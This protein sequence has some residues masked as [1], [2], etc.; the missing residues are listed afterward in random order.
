M[1]MDELYEHITKAIDAP[2]GTKLKAVQIF[3]A[4]DEYLIDALPG[5][6]EGDNRFEFDFS[7]YTNKIIPNE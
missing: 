2:Y 4:I 6:V 7:K 3:L 1:T 5:Y